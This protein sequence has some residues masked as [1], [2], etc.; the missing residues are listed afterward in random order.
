MALKNIA[1]DD[2]GIFK[3][4]GSFNLDSKLNIIKGAND[5]GKNLFYLIF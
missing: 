3:K 5:S 4:Q 2:N 1:L